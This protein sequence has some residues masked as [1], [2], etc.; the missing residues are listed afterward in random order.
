MYVGGRFGVPLAVFNFD[1]DGF[2]ALVAGEVDGAGVFQK[3]FCRRRHQH[4]FRRRGSRM[5]RSASP[6]S[7]SE[8]TVRTMK[9][10]GNHMIQGALPI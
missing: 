3:V 6:E 4:S 7:C 1:V 10:P 9:M 5:S 8:N 2:L